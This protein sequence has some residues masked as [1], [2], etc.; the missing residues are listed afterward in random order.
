MVGNTDYS[1]WALHHVV[2][3]QD[4]KRILFP[5]AYDFDLSGMVHPPYAVVD[6]RLRIRSVTDRLYRGPCRTVEELNAAAEPFR[7]KK[8]DMIG[9]VESTKELS[10]THRNE[11]KDY[12]DS[13]FRAV[14]SPASIKKTF[15]DGCKAQPT[16]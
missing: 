15:V 11:M 1:I 12:L 9:L 8:A 2:I 3:V 10:G 14:E 6:P 5:V 4:K 13:F 16:M 7:A